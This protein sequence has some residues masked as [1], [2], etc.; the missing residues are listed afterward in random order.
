MS[1]LTIHTCIDSK[2]DDSIKPFQKNN[3]FELHLSRLI[4]LNEGAKIALA[5]ISLADISFQ[6]WISSIP[7]A[8]LD[9]K[10]EVTT[11]PF[12]QENEADLSQQKNFACLLHRLNAERDYV[13]SNF[14][15]F[16][17]VRKIKELGDMFFQAIYTGPME[18]DD[19]FKLP[20]VKVQI[21]IAGGKSAELKNIL[22]IE[23]EDFVIGP[24]GKNFI[25]RQALRNPDPSETFPPLKI[26]VTIE[27]MRGHFLI[28]KRN[29][30]TLDDLI[31]AMNETMNKDLQGLIRISNQENYFKEE[32]T[33]NE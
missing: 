7:P 2:M 21:L 25:S 3:D 20:E 9:K 13:V 22:G 32:R 18:T 10:I 33:C 8:V 17:Q 29:V 26:G 5:D 4:Y 12:R 23:E 19:K 6:N 24:E 16:G 11:E 1:H 27:S 28:E 31:K 30:K 14:V 15:E